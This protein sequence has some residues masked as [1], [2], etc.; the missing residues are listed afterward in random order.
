MRP[1]RSVTSILPSGKNASDHGYTS[2]LAT[3]WI[4]K[5]PAEVG[6]TGSAAYAWLT[7][8]N[9]INAATSRMPISLPAAVDCAA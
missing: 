6:T 3:V 7:L 9:T 1:G 2:P 4:F 8:R 5:L